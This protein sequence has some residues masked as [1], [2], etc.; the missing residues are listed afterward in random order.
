MRSDNFKCN[1]GAVGKKVTAMLGMSALQWL[2]EQVLS[3]FLVQQ[4]WWILDLLGQKELLLSDIQCL[5]A[6]CSYRQN[7][8][9]QSFSSHSLMLLLL[10]QCLSVVWAWKSPV[11]TVGKTP[12]A[13]HFPVFINPR[14]T[15][16][17]GYESKVLSTDRSHLE[18][19]FYF[20]VLIKILLFK[21]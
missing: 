6:Q 5:S 13:K 2:E 8:G 4:K 10:L 15:Y 19:I 17:E 14:G 16:T 12:S 20:H 9:F 3:I 18:T 21:N 7:W 11:F 1:E